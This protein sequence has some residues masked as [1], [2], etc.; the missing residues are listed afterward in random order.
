MIYNLDHVFY[1]L[2]IA[3][4]LKLKCSGENSS[5]KGLGQDF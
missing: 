1:N 5:V 4:F 3:K 2:G